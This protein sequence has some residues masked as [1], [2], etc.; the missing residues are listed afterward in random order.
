MTGG[1]EFESSVFPFILRGVSIIGI[2]S[3]FTPIKL[4]RRVW[5]RLARDLKPDQYMI[6][7]ILSHSRIF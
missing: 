1:T 2:D 7:S 4:R 5:R 3:V 6:S